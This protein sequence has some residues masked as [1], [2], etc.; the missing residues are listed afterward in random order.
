MIRAAVVEDEEKERERIIS[1]LRA[2]E[3]ERG[4]SFSITEFSDGLELAEDYKGVFDILF[5]DIELPHLDGMKT[6]KRIRERDE[7]VLILF[8]TNLAQYAI[9]GYEVG[10]LDY[11][12][13]PVSYAAFAMKLGRAAKILQ[14]RPVQSLVL[15]QDGNALRL[16]Y[17][18]I[19]YVEVADHQLIYHTTQGEYRE[20]RTLKE[21]EEILGEGFSRINHCYLV[22]LRFVEGTK[23]EFCL[24]G[25]DQLK[26]SRAKKKAFLQQLSDFY[27]YGGH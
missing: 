24:L 12:L 25:Q 15:N 4:V 23:D 6:A 3:K 1:Y 27:L 10:A 13:K 26:I 2:F 8:I 22:N 19:R 11:M 21:L 7:E 14:G 16:P 18:N 20:F 9:Q 5:L 17:G